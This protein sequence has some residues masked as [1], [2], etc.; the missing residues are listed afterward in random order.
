MEQWK[1][2]EKRGA[3]DAIVLRSAER[4]GHARCNLCSVMFTA[5]QGAQN[6][7]LEELCCLPCSTRSTCTECHEWVESSSLTHCCD[8]VLCRTCAKRLTYE[9]AECEEA[10]WI[11]QGVGVYLTLSHS[12]YD[13]VHICPSCKVHYECANCGCIYDAQRNYTGIAAKGIPEPCNT[14]DHLC[15]KCGPDEED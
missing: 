7:E 4:A 8:D 2:L 5:S 14:D 1:Q 15:I 12:Q 9:C 10:C 11:S 3:P 6:D 13:D